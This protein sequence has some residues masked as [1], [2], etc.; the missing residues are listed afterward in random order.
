[1]LFTFAMLEKRSMPLAELPA[2]LERIAILEEINRGYLK[3]SAAAFAEW[4]V[5][6]LERAGALLRRDGMVLARGR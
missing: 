2:Y 1:M 4:L 3:M 5:A 6:D